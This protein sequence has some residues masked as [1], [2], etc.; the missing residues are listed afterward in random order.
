MFVLY[1]VRSIIHCFNAVLNDS[2]SRGGGGGGL[3]CCWFCLSGKIKDITLTALTIAESLA[4]SQAGYLH[5][6]WLEHSL[7]RH[8]ILVPRRQ[9]GNMTCN[10]KGINLNV[11]PRRLV[12]L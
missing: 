1:K 6:D 10:K 2:S 7:L 9:A 11:D 4:V 12:C 5:P 8:V 3:N